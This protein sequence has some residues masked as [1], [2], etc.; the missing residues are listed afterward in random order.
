MKK[1]DKTSFLCHYTTIEA[2]HNMLQNIQRTEVG[3]CNINFWASR[4]FEMNDTE[5]MIYAYDVL[6]EILPNIEKELCIPNKYRIS[7]L[8]DRYK[9][10]NPNEWNSMLKES[11][12]SEKASSYIVS[13][14]KKID[15]LDMWRTYSNDGKGICIVFSVKELKEQILT[16]PSEIFYG[17]INLE[18]HLY[19]SL[20]NFYSEYYEKIRV[21]EYNTRSD[22]NERFNFIINRMLAFT[23]YIKRKEFEYEA[24]ERIINWKNLDKDVKFR[25]SKLGNVVPYILIPI[26]VKSITK[27][28]LGPC[29]NFLSLKAGLEMEIKSKGLSIGI[30]TSNIPYRQF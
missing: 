30:E 12:Y 6:W 26:P 7:R 25:I 13:M 24:E 18:N 15:K 27:I 17:E 1:Q 20:K 8:W 21:D 19:S 5:E 10:K 16:T 28:I 22:F 3:C 11:L 9:S 23:P 2:F 29:I 4:I 14:S